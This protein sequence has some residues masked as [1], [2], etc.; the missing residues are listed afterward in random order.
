[1]NKGSLGYKKRLYAIE[2]AIKYVFFFV[3]LV[4][5]LFPYIF[6]VSK[7]LMN[8]VDINSP[9]ILFLPTKP[10][11]ANYAVFGEYFKYFLNSFIVVIINAFF[12]PLTSCLVAFPLARYKFKGDTF[13]FTLILA[14]SMIPSSVIQVPQYQLFVK[15]GLTDTLASQFIGSFFGGSGMQIFLIIQFMRA[16]PKELDE[17]AKIDGANKLTIF[18]RIM[19]PLCLNVCIY[20]G[21]SI[22]IAKWNDFQGPLIY[23]KT[24]SKRTMA[25]AFYYHFGSSG[26]ASLLNNV[27]MAMATC[28]TIFPAILFFI[29]QKQMIGGVKIG[30]VKG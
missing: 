3:L 4:F 20:L 10:T 13:I 21:V 12:V 14:T 15:F 9:E 28:M 8:I 29:F 26:D 30:A 25:V 11:L 16:L 17:A 1:M 2:C 22:A 19:L 7:S 24:D 18:I 27:K 6:M 5:L 23:L